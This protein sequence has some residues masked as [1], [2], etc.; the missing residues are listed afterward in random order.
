MK[1]RKKEEKKQQYGLE[2]YKS[3]SEYEKTKLVEYRKKYY[4]MRKMLYYTYKI[5][6]LIKIYERA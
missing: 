1:R 4:K 5:Y 6:V 2:R 3:L